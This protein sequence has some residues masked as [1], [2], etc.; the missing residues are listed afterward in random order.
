MEHVYEPEEWYEMEDRAEH[1]ILSNRA[2][3][4]DAIDKRRRGQH[5]D[6]EMIS[7]WP[8][9]RGTPRKPRKGLCTDS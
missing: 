3:Q 6:V 8:R 1:G 9:V 2:D 4:Q 5:Q 7:I